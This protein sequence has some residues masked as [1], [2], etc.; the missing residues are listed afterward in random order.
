M[1][2]LEYI[3]IKFMS[4]PKVDP[5]SWTNPGKLGNQ[6]DMSVSVIICSDSTASWMLLDFDLT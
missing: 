3:W 5:H 4:V 6:G 1:M 2:S